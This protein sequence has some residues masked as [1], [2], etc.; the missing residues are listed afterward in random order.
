MTLLLWIRKLNLAIV[1]EQI[2][3]NYI[4]LVFTIGDNALRNAN[5]L[6]ALMMDN[7]RMKFLRQ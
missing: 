6:S 2:V 1:L 4:A 3:Y 7:I 5:V